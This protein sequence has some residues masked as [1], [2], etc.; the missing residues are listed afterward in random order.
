MNPGGPQCGRPATC[1]QFHVEE[2]IVILAKDDFSVIFPFWGAV[3]DSSVSPL[4]NTMGGLSGTRGR[5]IRSLFNSFTLFSTYSKVVCF[6]LCHSLSS[7]RHEESMFY[8]PR[9]SFSVAV[10]LPALQRESDQVQAEHDLA[11]DFLARLRSVPSVRRQLHRC[12]FPTLMEYAFNT[13]CCGALPDCAGSCRVC[14]VASGLFD[15]ASKIRGSTH[16][17]CFGHT[18][19]LEPGGNQRDRVASAK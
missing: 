1:N 16:L 7:L 14:T 4:T 3:E 13:T 10:L 9:I 6:W 2:Q 15:C 19:C 17:C 11:L 12:D 18:P 8:F 5:H